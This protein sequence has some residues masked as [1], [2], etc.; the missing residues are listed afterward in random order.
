MKDT[1]MY[2]YMHAHV[3]VHA[4]VHV[5]VHAC[6]HSSKQH[7]FNLKNMLRGLVISSSEMATVHVVAL[8]L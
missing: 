6:M 7:N 3:H 5:H 1:Y 2:M 8:N 4:R